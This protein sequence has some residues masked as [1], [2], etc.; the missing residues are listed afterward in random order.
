MILVA[1]VSP[2]CEAIA[3]ITTLSSLNFLARSTPISTWLP[4]TSKSIAFP[5]SWSSPALL[6]KL[7]FSPSSAAIIP[8]RWAT[9]LECC[10]AFWP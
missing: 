5:I 10:N 8:A 4:S 6:A 3:L 7:T 2:W 1:S 9:S